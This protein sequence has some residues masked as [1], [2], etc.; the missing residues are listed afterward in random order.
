MVQDTVALYHGELA[1]E[2][3]PLGG[4]AVRLRISDSRP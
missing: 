4:L 2:T 1:L 3:S